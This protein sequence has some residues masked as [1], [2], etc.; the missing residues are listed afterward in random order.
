MK[1]I[2]KWEDIDCVAE[3]EVSDDTPSL[4]FSVYEIVGRCEDKN[5]EWTKP[6]YEKKGAKS[7]DDTTEN[8]AE[9]QTLIH[10]YIKWDACSHIYFGDEEGYIHVCGG[11][12][13]F[14]LM[15]AIKRIWAIA[16]EKLPREHSAEMFDSKLLPLN[17]P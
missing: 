11:E 5:G 10:G 8:L 17:Q 13:W 15:E 14:Q 6:F 4:N 1:Q 2:I 12:S 3:I 7:S 9:A 16:C